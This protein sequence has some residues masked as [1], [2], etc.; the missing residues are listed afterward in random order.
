MVKE[1]HGQF[2]FFF[3]LH[4]SANQMSAAN[5]YQYHNNTCRYVYSFDNNEQIV[6]ILIESR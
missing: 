2:V 3:F 4:N 6:C 1:K 5:L